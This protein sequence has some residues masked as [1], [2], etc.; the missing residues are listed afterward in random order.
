M[1]ALTSPPPRDQVRARDADHFE[2]CGESCLASALG[3]DVESV[4]A[5]LRQHEGGE[6]AVHSGTTPRVLIDFCRS[7]GIG[8][9]EVRGP[10]A[11]YV[12]SAVAR[13]HY[14]LVAV[15]SDHQ[16]NPVPRAQSAR[17]H[18][19]GIGHWLLGYGTAGSSVDVMQPWGGRLLRYNLGG[20]RDQQ[21]G[22]EIDRPVAGPVPV[23]GPVAKP[24]RPAAPKPAPPK[25]PA[26]RVYVVKRGDTL[27]AIAA[28]QH[29]T[30]QALMRANPQIKN[31]NLILVGQRIT[32]PT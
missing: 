6:R 24:G 7:R 26:P 4:T 8:A 12:A 25:K 27:A 14:A 10:A 13:G 19:G 32:V 23:G 21:L 28:A 18:S 2:L 30:L 20:G 11:Q 17:L 29:V 1:S 22:V 3:L 15:W 16:G 5:W 31:P 9:R